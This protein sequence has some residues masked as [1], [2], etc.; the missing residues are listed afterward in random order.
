MEAMPQLYDP[1]FEGK[2]RNG[3]GLDEEGDR[4]SQRV[5]MAIAGSSIGIRGLNVPMLPTEENAAARVYTLPIAPL[6]HKAYCA[7][8]SLMFSLVKMD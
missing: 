4:I 1:C 2:L 7:A 8:L 3:F 5:A 6:T